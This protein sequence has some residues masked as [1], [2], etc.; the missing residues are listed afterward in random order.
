ME[1][2]TNFITR[3]LGNIRYSTILIMVFI[4]T[5]NTLN[6]QSDVPNVKGS[7]SLL[8]Q[9]WGL[10][11]LGINVNHNLNH[12]LSLNAGVG[13]GLQFHLGANFYLNKRTEKRTSFFIGAQ[14]GLIREYYLSGEFGDSQLA[15]Y[16]PIG[17]EY[18]AS[19]GFT[20]Q[21]DVGPNFVKNDWSQSNTSSFLASIKIGYTFRKKS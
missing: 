5:Q 7:T 12:W 21:L 9:V 15:I 8:G 13:I 17:F 18:R 14:T 10:E 1:N 16:L 20:I 3:T 19:K 4:L 2:A 6:A 11:I